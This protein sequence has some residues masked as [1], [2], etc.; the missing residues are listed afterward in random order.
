MK[1]QQ[2]EP[3]NPERS[4]ANNAGEIDP[5]MQAFEEAKVPIQNKLF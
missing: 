2:D 3:F 4:F 1:L 5:W